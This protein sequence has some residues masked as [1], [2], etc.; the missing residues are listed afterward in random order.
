MS[1]AGGKRLAVAVVAGGGGTN[2]TVRLAP[3]RGLRW[4]DVRAEAIVPGA[5]AAVEVAV[6][7]D[8]SIAAPMARGAVLIVLQT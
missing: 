4:R 5:A 3:L 6:E 8:G 2:V 1:V 7:A